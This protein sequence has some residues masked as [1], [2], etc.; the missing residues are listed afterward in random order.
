MSYGIEDLRQAAGDVLV[1]EV[2]RVAV[3]EPPAQRGVQPRVQLR[4]AVGEPT[5]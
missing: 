1:L 5:L 3:P 4:K 2:A